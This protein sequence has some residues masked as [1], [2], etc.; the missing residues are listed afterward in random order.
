M[1]NLES[2]RISFKTNLLLSVSTNESM[3]ALWIDNFQLSPCLFNTNLLKATM[4]NF[5]LAIFHL[6][7][8][9]SVSF[10]ILCYKIKPVFIH[11]FNAYSFTS[12]MLFMGM[13]RV[14][15]EKFSLS[16]LHVFLELWILTQ[17]LYNNGTSFWPFFAWEQ[18]LWIRYFCF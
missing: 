7:V 18:F 11:A 10:C 16:V 4:T 3:R 13:P 2:T 8:T 1:Y 15:V 5:T 9:F 12:T 14:L 17:K 6:S